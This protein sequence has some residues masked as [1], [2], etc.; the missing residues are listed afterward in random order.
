MIH[1]VQNPAADTEK[2]RV[3]VLFERL[4]PYHH[5]RLNAA[6]KLLSVWGIEAC[7][8]E[9][10]YA[11]DKVEGS[12]FFQRR[13]L[14]S[15]RT[16]DPEWRRELHQAMW[17]ALDDIQPQVVVV[18]GWA[19]P[20]AFSSLAWCVA[21]KVPAVVMTESTYWDEPRSAGKEWVKSRIVKLCAAGFAG[22]TPH[23]EY[24]ARLGV[25][26]EKISLGYDIV[27]ND[28]F[29]NQADFVRGAAATNR[30]L[31]GLPEKFFLASARFVEKKNLPGLIRA[32]GR[33]RDLAEQEN[34]Q[35]I[36]DLVLLGDGELKPQITALIAELGLTDEV[37]LPGFKQYHE[38]PAYFG[39]AQVFVHASTT[40]QWGLV[41]NEAMA[42]G[43]PVL[44]SNRCGCAQDLVME[45]ANG[46]A[47]T[48]DHTEQLAQLMLK[49]SS[50]TF[51]LAEFGRESRRIIANWGPERFATGLRD[52]VNAA[53]KSPPRNA[54][55]L[56]RLLLKLMLKQ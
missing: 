20:D 41:V 12:K 49:L 29:A 47:F 30:K 14:T 7:A 45:N 17:H 32:Y 9:T 56:D 33:Y 52:A 15:R 50:S 25:P 53:L 51:P 5:A 1:S 46:F 4:G 6:G 39:L 28:H 8:E 42:S 31:H 18:P 34:R 27:D 44:V 2:T 19:S 26:R 24:L 48:P 10:T 16:D 38:L 23:A 13:T 40:E 43:L 54:S 36:W 37:Y 22:G 21:R 11:W 3:A 35:D 55:A